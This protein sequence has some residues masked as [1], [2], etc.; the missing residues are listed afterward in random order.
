LLEA[1]SLGEDEVQQRIG[2][3]GREAALGEDEYRRLLDDL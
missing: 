2:S 3:L 1:L